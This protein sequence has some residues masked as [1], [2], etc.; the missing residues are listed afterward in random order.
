[1]WRCVQ[2]GLIQKWVN[3]LYSIYLEE[4]LAKKTPEER[5]REKNAAMIKRDDGLVCN[6]G[7]YS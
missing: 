3:D 4:S 2:G 7:L 5:Q 6:T 1:M